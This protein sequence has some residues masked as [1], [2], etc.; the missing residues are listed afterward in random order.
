MTH[1]PNMDELLSEFRTRY[2]VAEDDPV[3]RVIVDMAFLSGAS[4]VLRRL[5]AARL[6]GSTDSAGDALLHE[7]SALILETKG[8]AAT[9]VAIHDARNGKG[10]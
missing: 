2:P 1:T 5:Q 3:L 6:D 8:S 7:T 10:S 4:S 9:M